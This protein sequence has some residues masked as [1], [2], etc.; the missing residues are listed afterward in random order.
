MVISEIAETDE[1]IR[2]SKA[3]FTYSRIGVRVDFVHGS[4]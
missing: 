3:S 1:E 4:E 2:D